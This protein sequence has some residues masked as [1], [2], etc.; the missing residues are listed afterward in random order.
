MTVSRKSL[1][2]RKPLKDRI[3]LAMVAL[4]T[5]T[6]LY[7]CDW[8]GPKP[9]G[10]VEKANI[11]VT[12]TNAFLPVIAQVKGFYEQEGLEVTM[13]VHPYG[14]QALENMLAGK[15]DIATM[16]ETPVMFAILNGADL[17]IIATIHKTKKD[18]AIVARSDKGIARPRDLIGKKIGAT[19][20]T[21]SDFFLSVFLTVNAIASEDIEL[22]DLQQTELT[23]AL[24]EGKIDAASV[25]SHYLYATQKQLGENGTTFYNKTIYTKTYNIVS[26][27][28]F[29]INNPE[30]VNKI[31]RAL[32]KA[33]I[34]FKRN[35]EDSLKIFAD[36]T[37]KD[38]VMI[39]EMITGTS[40]ELSLDQTLILALEDES[41]W[42]IDTKLTSSSK[43]PNYLHYIYFDGLK[44]VNPAAVNILK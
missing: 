28:Q 23:Q 38:I 27:K 31:L 7:A 35:P 40:A 42:A 26:T 8:M 1:T 44:S 34:F 2:H 10:P 36:Y 19:F 29:V 22:I 21:S 30:K 18:D 14:K 12:S 39:R 43:V 13:D 16:A 5:V 3:F 4:T 11:A 37:K 6:C 15:A 9:A 33:E 17:S 32:Y 20:G 41:Q 25:F 24:A